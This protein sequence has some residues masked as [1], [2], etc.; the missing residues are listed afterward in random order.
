MKRSFA[1]SLQ[2]FLLG[3]IGAVS[4]Y[5]SVPFSL[6]SSLTDTTTAQDHTVTY[7]ITLRW[8]G[9][10]DA[11]DL[12]PLKAPDAYLLEPVDSTQLNTHQ[13]YNSNTLNTIHAQYTF[14]ANEPGEG[15]ISYAVVEFTETDTG[16]KHVERTQPYD[17]TIMSRSR[18]ALRQ[19][20]HIAGWSIGG[21][22][23]LLIAWGAVV[24]TRRRKRKKAELNIKRHGENVDLEHSMLDELRDV[25]RHKLA[26]ETD[27]FFDGISKVLH[28]YF[29]KRY[30][31]SATRATAIDEESLI[32]KHDLPPA[33]MVEFKS[34]T[35][36]ASR[37]KFSG[38]QLSPDELE[39]WYK[40]AE[41]LIKAFIVQQKENRLNH[42]QNEGVNR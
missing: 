21:L 37:I 41:K 25:R 18:Y 20:A 8:I 5:A 27:K 32:R 39:R 23:V 30:G 16:I 22:A 40:R 2:L 42:I 15:R 9:A 10:P 11:I 1:L 26:G 35:A 31:F 12:L 36:A 24:I 13:V 33:L 4:S 34:I 28:T 14:R 38:E 29:E 7:T 3:T 17:V 19:T 6:D